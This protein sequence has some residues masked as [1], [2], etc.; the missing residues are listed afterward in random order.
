MHNMPALSHE[1]RASRGRVQY[2]L[3]ANGHIKKRLPHIKLICAFGKNGVA[4]TAII[5]LIVFALNLFTCPPRL[6]SFV[7][8]A[9]TKR[10]GKVSITILKSSLAG[11]E[12]SEPKGHLFFRAFLCFYSVLWCGRNQR[13]IFFNNE[14]GTMRPAGAYKGEIFNHLKLYETFWYVH[15]NKRAFAR[16]LR[17]RE[18]K[19]E[20]R[21]IYFVLFLSVWM[22]NQHIILR[23]RQNC[24]HEF[25]SIFPNSN[26]SVES[27]A[28]SSLL[29]QH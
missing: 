29:R 9:R 22:H 15:N 19:R 3:N 25:F 24:G 21:A 8:I 7:A 20:L 1:T 14:S 12:Q 23:G 4:L 28:F 11:S 26:G 17:A 27:A 13:R 10:T 2:I 16:I 6:C 18:R 5:H